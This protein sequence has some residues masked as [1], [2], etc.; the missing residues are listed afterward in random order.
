M[1]VGSSKLN[2]IVNKCGL[3]G[4]HFLFKIK[5]FNVN[6]IHSVILNGTKWSEESIKYLLRFF[7]RQ[8]DKNAVKKRIHKVCHS[9]HKLKVYERSSEVEN[10][11]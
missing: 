9:E 2:Y 4:S 8:N 5:F 1:A 7:I 3:S 6:I 11:I 10:G